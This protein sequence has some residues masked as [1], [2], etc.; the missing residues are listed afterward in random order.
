MKR[1]M[2]DEELTIS[3]LYSAINT[4]IWLPVS[5]QWRNLHRNDTGRSISAW[6]RSNTCSDSKLCQSARNTIIYLTLPRYLSAAFLLFAHFSF[7]MLVSI[8]KLKTDD[9]IDAL[10]VHV[11]VFNVN[12]PVRWI[13]TAYALAWVICNASSEIA[14]LPFH[15]CIHYSVGY[16]CPSLKKFFDKNAWFSTLNRIWKGSSEIPEFSLQ[17]SHNPYDKP[18]PPFIT[19][20]YSCRLPNF[21]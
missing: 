5:L 6:T 15:C 21:R 3:Y 8:N 1:F 13:Y 10:P 4:S 12:K 11:C 16:S 20:R 19:V 9:A 7:F 17:I 14:M 2:F 18:K